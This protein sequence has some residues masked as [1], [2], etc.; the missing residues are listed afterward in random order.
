MSRAAV[1]WAAASSG[2]SAGSGRVWLT[3]STLVTRPPSIKMYPV[4]SVGTGWRLRNGTART[5]SSMRYCALRPDTSDRNSTRSTSSVSCMAEPGNSAR[6]KPGT[7]W[8]IARATSWVSR[9]P[10]N[11]E[12]INRP[13]APA[14]RASRATR[15]AS[16]GAVRLGSTRTSSP[17]RRSR[18][19]MASSPA[20]PPP[21][22][23]APPGPAR[24]APL[25][26]RTRRRR[27][28]PPRADRAPRP[29]LPPAAPSR[30]PA[31]HHPARQNGPVATRE[32]HRDRP[33]VTRPERIHHSPDL[34]AVVE[35]AL[36][37]V[38]LD[39]ADPLHVSRFPFPASHPEQLLDPLLELA[40]LLQQRLDPLD[41][42]FRLR[43]EHSRGLREL[44][45][46]PSYQG[47]GAQPRHRL[48]AAD[49]G[50]RA[51][52]VREP[53]Q[54]DL[55]GGRNVR[56]AAQLERDSR[57]VD[58]TDDVAVF[59]GEERHRAC[60]DRLLVLHLPRCD[61]EVFP[62]VRVHLFLD[63]RQ[64]R[65]V[66]RPVVREVEPQPI[67]SDHRPLLAYVRTEDL[68][69]RGMHQVRR[70]VVA[71]DVLA[72]PLVHLRQ[73]GGRFERVLEVPD[74]GA[75]AIHLFH[76]GNVELPPFP[77]HSSRVTDLPA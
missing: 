71:L 54:R 63:A 45:L 16:A 28:R 11:D 53:K 77:L 13:A 40:V 7:A 43:L 52:L 49:A 30:G 37:D 76:L 18:K 6:G 17:G 46:E 70:R 25:A 67:G 47:V 22:R 26:L 32:Q 27:T 55:A 42:V 14:A 75:R 59:L 33:L 64:R 44:L 29:V 19:L 41:Q 50:G 4:D 8:R 62:D 51:R 74:D 10:S 2:L 73:D 72:P 1:A 36:I 35:I 48:D 21:D 69:Q 20:P 56:P 5:C 24:P 31:L 3:A 57:Y 66:D 34:V 23:R 12:P 58:H 38:Q 9:V 39:V 68:S 65:V 15:S 61:R 60:R